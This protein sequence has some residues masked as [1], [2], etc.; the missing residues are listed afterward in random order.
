MRCPTIVE[1]PPPVQD[2]TGWPWTEAAAPLP[3]DGDRPSVCIVTPSYNQRQYLEETIRSVLLQGY[4]NLQYFVIDGGSTDGSAEIIRKYEKWL[5]RWISEPDKGQADA[6]N[7]GFALSNADMLGWL[8][9]DDCLQ[10]DSLRRMVAAL[11]QDSRVE[12]VYGDADSGPDLKSAKLWRRGEPFELRT[13][14]ANLRMPIPQQGSLW[15][16]SV[17]EKVGALD[18]RWQVVLDRE[19]FLRVALKC[20]MKY[21]PGVV[22]FFRTHA[23]SK[24][25]AQKM[26]WTKEMPLMYREFFKRD[27]LPRKMRALRRQTMSAVYV[28]CAN[29]ARACGKGIVTG[30]RIAICITG[31]HYPRELYAKVA[32]G[33][34]GDVFV[35]S[36]R[37][38]DGTPGWLF[39]HVMSD[40]VFFE[41]NVG[42]DWGCYQQFIEKGAWKEYEYVFFMH[43]DISIRDFGF[44]KASVE[45]MAQGYKVIGNGRNS[46]KR[47]WP[48]THLECYTHSR[49]IPPSISFE[50]DTVRGSFL[51]TSREVLERLGSFEVFWDRMRLNV[52][53][54]NWS[55]LSTCGK[56]AEM[57]GEKT[58]GFL[59]EDYRAS[60]YIAEHER[61]PENANVALNRWSPR[62]WLARCVCRAGRACA[63]ARM[64][65]KDPV[66]ARTIV[67][68]AADR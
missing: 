9:S 58:F 36:H 54:G 32:E 24:S 56:L 27:D 37:P 15:R 7:K 35:V 23:D 30:S 48:R 29:H 26:Q 4:P 61:G 55:L 5:T 47:D 33:N 51:A 34:L 8:N 31:W 67:R 3:N 53:F 11:R 16:R 18:A 22:G 46:S 41:P 63:Q 40:H 17:H 49:W 45:L 64:S 44:V 13:F 43:D 6:I 14:L 25:V 66:F 28:W 12:F 20:R 42:Y 39:E 1:L 62:D 68:W 60:R 10:P 65:G 2:E 52:R 59:S 19:F 57:F 50:H 38:A 21:V